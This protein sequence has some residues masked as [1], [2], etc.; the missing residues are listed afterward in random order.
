MS[1][2]MGQVIQRPLLKE[3]QT[4]LKDGR[5]LFLSGQQGEVQAGKQEPSAD[6]GAKPGNHLSK[7]WGKMRSVAR[8]F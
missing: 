3:K 6:T 5:L 8:I 2:R 4:S 1:K 7:F